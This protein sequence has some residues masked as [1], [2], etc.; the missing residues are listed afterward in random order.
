MVTRII[1]VFSCDVNKAENIEPSRK[2]IVTAM[3]EGERERERERELYEI[4]RRERLG[5]Q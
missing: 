2:Y 5:I 3:R 1:Y 4:N